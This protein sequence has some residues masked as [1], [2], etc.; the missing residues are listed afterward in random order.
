MSCM[1][2]IYGEHFAVDHFLSQWPLPINKVWHKG[3]KSDLPDRPPSKHSGFNLVVSDADFGDLKGQIQD[4]IDF[5]NQFSAACLALKEEP[6]IDEKTLNFGIAFKENVAAQFTHFPAKLV[7]LAG[8]H[9]LAIEV[10]HYWVSE[11]DEC[12]C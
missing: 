8:A 3:D 10:S 11:D 9:N 1:L 2:R 4:A 6:G 7:S 5:L 12:D